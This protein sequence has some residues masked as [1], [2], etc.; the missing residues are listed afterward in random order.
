M[1]TS[2]GIDI[3]YEPVWFL[4][5][6]VQREYRGLPLCCFQFMAQVLRGVIHPMLGRLP[7][8]S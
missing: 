2:R 7:S 4:Q 1:A 3:E 6:P 8:L 5:E